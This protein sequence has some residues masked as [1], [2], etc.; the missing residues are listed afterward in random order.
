L[1]SL[2]QYVVAACS[3]LLLTVFSTSAAEAWTLTT[4]P[5]NYWVAVASSDNGKI[6]IAVSSSIYVS[7]N[8]GATW[9]E[10]TNA[11]SGY[12][13]CASISA[14]GS[15]MAAAMD[16]GRIYTSRDYGV[17]WR[18]TASPSNYWESIACSADG[19]KLAAAAF[20]DGLNNTVPGQIHLSSNSGASWRTPRSTL[21]NTNSLRQFWL[22]I[23]SSSDG[24]KLVA[25]NAAGSIYT[26]KNF[27]KNWSLSGAP[28]EPWF[29]VACSTNG[30]RI[31]VA[32]NGGPI[33]TSANKGRTWI[34][35]T[36]APN[37][38]WASV[39]SS[40]DGSK[41]AAVQWGGQIY[42][43]SDA[44]TNWSE[45][46]VPNTY[47]AD[48]IWGIALSKDGKRT[49]AAGDGP[50]G[51][52]VYLLQPVPILDLN[53]KGTNLIVSWPS[54]A[55]GFVLQQNSDLDPATW[56]DVV[57]SVRRHGVQNQVIISRPN[58]EQFYRLNFPAGVPP[59]SSPWPPGWLEF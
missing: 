25:V 38:G 36:N 20:S 40:G 24:S 50:Y 31:V 23:A 18:A 32:A 42:T 12:W 45:D 55:T 17:T 33:Y 37:A 6:L 28:S 47:L 13:V 57:A 56:V 54:S 1:K 39:T 46:N 44:G 3:V 52:P 19:R 30:E 49:L 2:F 29:S 8:A 26:S 9:K 34:A 48:G 41:F 21:E 53:R 58:G 15:K 10:A 22:S 11:P 43:S 35:C 7:T 14:N 16:G 5:Y 27:G 51:G 4:A 59:S